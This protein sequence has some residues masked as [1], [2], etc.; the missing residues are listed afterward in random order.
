M[1]PCQYEIELINA[2]LDGNELA[3]LNFEEAARMAKNRDQE[4]AASLI[5]SVETAEEAMEF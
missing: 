1:K 5:L 4:A 2:Y 3:Y